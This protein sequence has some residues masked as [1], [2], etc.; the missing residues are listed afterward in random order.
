[1]CRLIRMSWIY[2]SFGSAQDAPHAGQAVILTATIGGR[3]PS[4]VARRRYC[5]RTSPFWPAQ[6]AHRFGT[7]PRD[8]SPDRATTAN[9][10]ESAI[11][12]DACPANRPIATIR[13]SSG[14]CA[15]PRPQPRRNVTATIP[16]H[17][18]SIT[19]QF[20]FYVWRNGWNFLRVTNHDGRLFQ[21]RI[22]SV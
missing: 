2:E 1:M 11:S 12:A 16:K 14:A 19:D 10:S 15:S 21:R 4:M 6:P 7:A 3:Q 13:C 8:F 17:S 18:H 5:Q 22:V 9:G 20:C